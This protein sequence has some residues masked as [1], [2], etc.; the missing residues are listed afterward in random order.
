MCVGYLGKGWGEGRV[1]RIPREGMGEG[2]VCRI[3]R[4]GMGG[5]SCV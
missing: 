1:C 3:P 4:E 5:G 2:R